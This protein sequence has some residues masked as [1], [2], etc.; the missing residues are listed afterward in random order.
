MRRYKND[1][2]GPFRHLHPSTVRAAERHEAM[3]DFLGHEEWIG[4]DQQFI[5]DQVMYQTFRRF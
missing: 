2:T 5:D 1:L 4:R 3:S